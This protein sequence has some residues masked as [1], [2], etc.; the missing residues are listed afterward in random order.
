MI[1]NSK[2]RATKSE[3][4]EVLRSAGISEPDGLH[5]WEI[6]GGT[7]NT[8]YRIAVDGRRLVLKIAPR[9]G[10]PGMSYEHDL[11][12]TEAEFYRCAASALPVPEVVCV[13]SSRAILPCDWLLMTECPGVNWYEHR[14]RLAAERGALRE[15]LGAAVARLHRLTGKAFG[16]PQNDPVPDWPTAFTS[17]VTAVLEDAARYHVDLPVS[18]DR[19][20]VVLDAAQEALAEVHEPALVHFDL[21]DGNV[22]VDPDEVRITGVIDGERSFWGDPLADMASLGLFKMIEDDAE[23]LAGYRAAGGRLDLTTR[24]RLRLDL[25]RC[26]LYLIMAVEATPRGANGPDDEQLNRLVSRHLCDVVEHLER[27]LG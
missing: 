25:Y 4:V 14:E 8:A 16:Y 7:Y 1:N 24:T 2:S 13:D 18:A 23:F 11:L 10:T 15:Q 17:M 22:L 27:G 3:L 19:V 20:R 21:W 9:R 6:G 12:L 26:Y 5:A